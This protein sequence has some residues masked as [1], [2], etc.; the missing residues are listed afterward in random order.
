SRGLVA[1]SWHHVGVRMLTANKPIHSHKELAGLN[2]R[3]P[4]DAAWTAVW[5]ALGAVPRQVPF[6]DLPNA[7]KLGQIDAQENPPNFIRA[8]KLY[9]H[10]KY[11]MTT[12]HMPQRQFIFASAQALG[13]L[14]SAQL[15][16]VQD[17]ATEASSHAAGIADAE[18]ARDLAWLTGEGGMVL[19]D[20]DPT[21]IA[22]TLKPV[23]EALAGAEGVRVYG[24]ILALR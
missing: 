3:L 2:L 1:L 12:N 20:F 8:S 17:A 23:P 16:I 13:R 6:T 18:H 15:R 10:Q 9:A 24:Q 14:T 19:I 4:Q 7:L 5:R 22:D 21:G 11:L